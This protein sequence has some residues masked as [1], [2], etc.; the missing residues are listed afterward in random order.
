M[1][2]ENRRKLAH[3]VR[4][5]ATSALSAQK[6]V[7][8]LDVLLRMGWLDPN[9]AK[10]WRQG[11]IDYLERAVQTNLARISEAMHLFRS[12]A[13]AEGLVPTETDYVARTPQRQTLRFSKSGN[14]S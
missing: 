1:H 5:A 14:P 11:Q 2:P 6:Y 7:S 12:W 3:R 13:S 9:S 8:P 10:R 4:M